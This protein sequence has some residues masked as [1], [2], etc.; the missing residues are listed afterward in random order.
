M[1]GYCC[2]GVMRHANHLAQILSAQAGVRSPS[3]GVDV[4]GSRFMSETEHVKK[5]KINTFIGNTGHFD[6]E[7]ESAGSK[8]WEILKIVSSPP[9]SHGVNVLD[10]DVHLQCSMR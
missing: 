8:S 4:T 6:N 7:I 9:S 3:R 5:L 1:R 10:S 2:V